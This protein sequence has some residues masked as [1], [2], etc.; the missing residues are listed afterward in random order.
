MSPD[1]RFELYH[2]RSANGITSPLVSSHSG[3]CGIPFRSDSES[4]ASYIYSSVREGDSYRIKVGK[5]AKYTFANFPSPG[6]N[7]TTINLFDED[8]K[9]IYDSDGLLGI[10]LDERVIGYTKARRLNQDTYSDNIGT[11]QIAG[12]G[13]K[14]NP[15]RYRFH[16]QGRKSGPGSV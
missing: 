1:A 15:D 16:L 11:I 3:I 8:I 10:S 13:T 6:F 9:A 12:R 7:A 4:F 14:K 2:Y 5:P